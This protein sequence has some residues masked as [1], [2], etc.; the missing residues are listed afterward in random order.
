MFRG[1]K[2]INGQKR[3]PLLRK[4][5]PA[6]TQWQVCRVNIKSIAQEKLC[7]LCVLLVQALRAGGGAHGGFGDF[8]PR[9]ARKARKNSSAPQVPFR[10]LWQK[11]HQ[12]LRGEFFRYNPRFLVFLV[13]KNTIGARRGES[14][15][16]TLQN[17][18]CFS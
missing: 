5:R 16:A 1:R 4:T 9:K 17:F 3:L 13:A 18:S 6:H 15:F 14:S 2:Q 7:A 8:Y 12:S 10:F 11:H